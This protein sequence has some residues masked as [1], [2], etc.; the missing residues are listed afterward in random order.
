MMRRSNFSKFWGHALDTSGIERSV[1]F[2]DLRHTGNTLAAQA[3]ATMS[4]L[5]AR[6]GHA[7]ARAAQICL[8]TTSQR[9]RVVAE[10]LNPL[11]A[12]RRGTVVAR[13]AVNEPLAPPAAEIAHDEGPRIPRPPRWSG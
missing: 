10:A 12:G 1:H 6:M 7:S 13:H 2:H 4:D 3:G 9:D 8:H 11:L 5:M